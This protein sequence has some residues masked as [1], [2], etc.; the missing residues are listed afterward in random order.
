MLLLSNLCPADFRSLKF[1]INNRSGCVQDY[2]QCIPFRAK[3]RYPQIGISTTDIV[4]S[5]RREGQSFDASGVQENGVHSELDL[6]HGTVNALIENVAVMGSTGAPAELAI[7]RGELNGE[8]QEEALKL[9]H[10]TTRRD[11]DM[12]LLPA[13]QVLVIRNLFA[14]RK[15]QY[16]VKNDSLFFA[17]DVPEWQTI[18]STSQSLGGDGLCES[19]HRIIVRPNMEN[20]LAHQKSILKQKYVEEHLTIYN[21]SNPREKY[22]VSLRITAGHLRNFFAAPG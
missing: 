7:Y 14:H 12:E 18:P 10:P 17:T 5:T 22:T 20:L 16:V 9:V 19:F 21:R 15:L 11:D 3:C 13:Q 6:D 4:F 2:R 8:G 1:I